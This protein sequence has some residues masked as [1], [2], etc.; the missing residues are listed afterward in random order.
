MK[1]DPGIHIVKHLVFFRKIRCDKEY[2]LDK[3]LLAD[4]RERIAKFLMEQVNIAGGKFYTNDVVWAKIMY[5][6]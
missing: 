3:S 6:D 5:G 2:P 4:V 1:L